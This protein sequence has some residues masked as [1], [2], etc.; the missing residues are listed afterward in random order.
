MQAQTTSELAWLA[1]P[2]AADDPCGAGL[3]GSPLLVQLDAQRV[4][5]LLTAPAAEPDWRTIQSRAISALRTTRDFRALAHLVAAQLHTGT[6]LDVLP[7]FG[8]I[9]TWLARY[10]DEVHP[11]LDDDA[12]ERRNVLNCFADRVAIVDVLRRLPLLSHAQL[13]AFSLRDIDIAMGLQPNPDPDRE[14]RSAQEVEAALAASERT[15]V[16][17]LRNAA[18]EAHEAL[19]GAQEIMRARAGEASIPQFDALVAQLGR[20]Q[21]VLNV[22]TDDVDADGDR[23]TSP[24]DDTTA[25]LAPGATGSIRSRYDA[26]RALE[27]VAE[28]FRRHEPSSPVALL[29]ERAKRVVSMDFLAVLAEL[30][31]DA[32]EQARRATGAQSSKDAEERA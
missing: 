31:P 16:I 8:L 5:G 23:S 2:V 21:K 18:S 15:S 10:W 19:L 17:Q 28:Y 6:L 22:R 4:F 27:A 26:V 3:D 13:G 20:I 25:P 14:P 30:A 9:N 12:L 32:L 24:T 29:V 7:L 11:R 1:E